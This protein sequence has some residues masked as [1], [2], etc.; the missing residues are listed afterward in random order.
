MKGKVEP[1][2]SYRDF[3]QHYPE[4]EPD[5]AIRFLLSERFKDGICCVECG[6]VR[7]VKIS[8]R[9]DYRCHDCKRQFAPLSGTIFHSSKISPVKWAYALRLLLLNN[10]YTAM[11]LMKELNISYKAAWTMLSK[12]R[13]ILP[14]APKIQKH[15]DDIVELDEA[16]IGG[17]INR[18]SQSKRKRVLPFVGNVQGRDT[19]LKVPI[20]AAKGRNGLRVAFE[21]QSVKGD[22]LKRRIAP[23]LEPGG[24]IITDEF[25]AYRAFDDVYRREIVQHGQKQYVNENPKYVTGEKVH[26]NGVE[27]EFNQIES[28][29]LG[30]HK[31]VS[32]KHMDSYLNEYC[33]RKNHKRLRAEPLLRLSLSNIGQRITYEDLTRFDCRAH[34]YSGR[35]PDYPL[36]LAA[37]TKKRGAYPRAK[38]KMFADMGIEDGLRIQYKDTFEKEFSGLI[39]ISGITPTVSI[40]PVVLPVQPSFDTSIELLKYVHELTGK[41]LL[42]SPTKIE[43]KLDRSNNRLVKAMIKGILEDSDD[44]ERRALMQYFQDKSV[45]KTMQYFL[46]R[47]MRKEEM[48]FGHKRIRMFEVWKGAPPDFPD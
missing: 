46:H 4:N 44:I 30:V 13:R 25:P 39:N 11:S 9:T 12:L 19:Q 33:F 40:A 34:N 2:S 23:Y 20:V 27:S 26:N 37:A 32:K 43:R 45:K 5:R 36:A 48:E 17:S 16:Y 7:V 41:M 47:F 10:G 1:L 15:I 31:G 3:I 18:W 35:G 38:L 22:Y 6:S 21:V 28:M 8:T 24:I 29:I 14:S 42:A